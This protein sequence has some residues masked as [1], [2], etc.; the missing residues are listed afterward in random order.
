MAWHWISRHAQSR[1]SVRGAAIARPVPSYL[2]SGPAWLL[3]A[4][5]LAA[6]SLHA[7]SPKDPAG[8]KAD[9]EPSAEADDQPSLPCAQWIVDR[10][11]WKAR[12]VHDRQ[13]VREQIERARHEAALA[14][15]PDGWSVEKSD[16]FLVLYH[17]DKRYAKRMAAA[18]ELYFGWLDARFGEVSDEYVRR[19]I[20]RICADY[21]EQRRVIR[22]TKLAA[23]ARDRDEDDS[24]GA[25][26]DEDS[27]TRLSGPSYP[28]ITFPDKSDI[29]TYY[30]GGSQPREFRTVFSAVLDRYLVDKDPLLQRYVPAWLRKG[31][32][33]MTEGVQVKGRKLEWRPSD[34]ERE[35]IAADLRTDAMVPIDAVLRLNDL[36]YAE[37][38][39]NDPSVDY[40]MTSLVRFLLEDARRNKLAKDLVPRN[41]AGDDPRSR[42]PTLAARQPHRAG[43]PARGREPRCAQRTGRKGARGVGR[44]P[45]GR[46]R[47]DARSNQA[48][49][50]AGLAQAASPLDQK[51]RLNLGFR[52]ATHP[53]RERR[54][55]RCGRGELA[56]PSVA[57]RKH[58]QFVWE[59][60]IPAPVAEVFAFHERPDAFA[61]LQPP[62]E[63]VEI[64]QPPT[65]LE[66]GTRVELR[67]K[68][69]PF[70]LR[71]V[72]E[73]VAY[74]KNV[75][76]EDV[77]HEGPFAAWH[78]QHLFFEHEGGCRLRDEIDY[79]PPLGWL[80]RLANGFAIRP[81]LRKMF[82]FRHQVTRE[83][84]LAACGATA[85]DRRS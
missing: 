76:F 13:D 59:S 77:M 45:Q 24:A 10:A 39:E 37:L 21:E 78:H 47:C 57:A 58:M 8:A 67:T 43:G 9:P 38:K 70:W 35:A 50:A 75:R 16:R 34:W 48:R 63:T 60:V 64:L 1:V 79:Q 46:V 42:G 7:Q 56:S 27:G 29:V 49:Q 61:L 30:E 72:A 32:Y 20:V 62:W 66:V 4:S 81:R 69:G 84:V 26:T 31:L 44:P 19:P 3:F 12:T 65:S 36:Q 2:A 11:A 68:V 55:N 15:L 40:T 23:R 52:V 6:S 5:L 85:S 83:Q 33:G 74:Q 73:H 53:D 14:A 17:C 22:R 54:A 25:N 28:S 80:G 71:V 41:H 82:A 18:L 51:G